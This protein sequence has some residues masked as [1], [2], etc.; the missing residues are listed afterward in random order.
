MSLR[1]FSFSST[2]I[3]I[4]KKLL[5]EMMSFT[6][7]LTLTIAV[8]TLSDTIFAKIHRHHASSEFDFDWG[9][10][11]VAWGRTYNLSLSHPI[12]DETFEV[13]KLIENYPQNG[14]LS[15]GSSMLFKLDLIKWE[16]CRHM[17]WN[18]SCIIVQA[19]SS[20][21]THIGEEG[22]SGPDEIFSRFS[23]PKPQ[24]LSLASLQLF[25]RTPND[26]WTSL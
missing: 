17:L 21:Y 9:W 22:N 18:A 20:V 14:I 24:S 23:Y 12:V 10:N 5:G 26:E 7:V 15:C 1:S 11:S 8:L 13:W 6:R 16:P 25:R 3:I 19:I 2:G 4:R